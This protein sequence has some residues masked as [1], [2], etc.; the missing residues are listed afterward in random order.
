MPAIRSI[1]TVAL[2]SVA[3]ASGAQGLDEQ[4]TA[5]QANYREGD[6]DG[7]MQQLDPLLAADDLDQP[8]ADR[9][10]LVASRVLQSRGEEHFRHARI[11]RSIADFDRHLQMQ[12]D[13]AAEHWQRGI[14]YY[15]AA[16]YEN[17]ARQFKLHQTVNPQDVENAVWHFLCESRGPKGTA[18]TARKNLIPVTR[19]ARVPMAQIQQLFAGEM[20]PEDVLQVGEESGG[21]AKFYADLYVG[22]YYEAIGRDRQSLRLIQSAAE[23]PA[24]KDNYMGDVARVHVKLRTEATYLVAARGQSDAG[25]VAHKVLFLAGGPSHGFG[26]HDHWAGCNL[27][28]KSLNEAGLSIEAKV[29]RSGW[30]QDAKA[31][32]GVDCVVMYGDGGAGHMVTAHLAELDAL[33]K[34]GV[35]VV[36]LHYA[37]ETP[38]GPTGD[39]FLEWIGG[40]FE[41]GW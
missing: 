25:E 20:T 5:A 28:A 12:P 26:A 6:F 21:T 7:A 39:K 3:A 37:V 34:A 35:G 16:E 10:R 38:K 4:L 1:L 30:P 27:L 31:F 23:N 24:G 32:D 2:L 36:C 13:R 19:D 18:E 11:A 33:A 22:L 15:Y 9:V 14:A 41:M 29:Y 17:G 40:Y 8:T